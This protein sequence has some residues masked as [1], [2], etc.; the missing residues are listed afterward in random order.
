LRTLVVSDLHLGSQTK[1]DV[2]RDPAQR[3]PLL[4]AAGTCDRLVLLGD[5]LEL[6]HGPERVAL[7]AAREFLS[8]LGAALGP[9]REVVILP[10]N[11]DYH[12]L[13]GWMERR[14]RSGP[15]PALG[16]QT[17]VDWESPD[18]L[19]KIAGWLAPARVSAAYPGI[20]LRA[21]VYAMHG[22]YADLHLTI[23][24]IER[25]AA[26][27][28]GRI[29]GLPAAGPR[30]T[31]DYEAALAP[32]YAW[33]HAVAQR[34]DPELGGSL[35][36]GSVRGW[37]ALTGP[38]RRGLRQRALAAGF[39]LLVAALNRARIGPLRSELSGAALRRSGLRGLEE[40]AARLGVGARHV[41]FGHTHRA[42]PLPGDDA[43]EWRTR[44]G[45]GLINSGCWVQEPS[46]LGPNPRQS[47]YR[48]G[49][50]VW[51]GEQGPPELVNLLD[52]GS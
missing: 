31:E 10:G 14:A 42:G 45:A 23:P 38:G 17:T 6:R 33:V 18:A 52:P 12:L 46:F 20:W 49:F 13:D 19:A 40:A 24:T 5:L 34:I 16:L 21:D 15:P 39:P 9:E 32:I 30:C 26:G 28:M 2:L 27:V 37:R 36:G 51:V 50:C 4:A 1:L 22:H 35:H 29:V 7:Q 11:H 41:I 44:S 25:L 3:K 43:S 47:P 8:E 48:V